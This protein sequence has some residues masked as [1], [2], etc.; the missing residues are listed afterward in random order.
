MSKISTH[1]TPR[2]WL[3]TVL[4][5]AGNALPIGQ[6]MATIAR[7]LIE[8]PEGLT[9]LQMLAAAPPGIALN[10]PAL[11]AQL[12]RVGAPIES[13]P[14]TGTDANGQIVRFV[15]YRLAGEMEVRREPWPRNAEAAQ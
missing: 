7:L 4:H 2:P 8:H 15:R 3:R 5:V 6:R 14:T 13:I 11:I 10:A 12:R 9:R 1:G